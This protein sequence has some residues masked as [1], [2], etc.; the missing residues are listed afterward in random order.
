[1]G[2]EVRAVALAM[3]AAGYSVLPITIGSKKPSIHSWAPYQKLRM[4][5][6][7]IERE[8]SKDVQIAVICGAIS[9]CLEVIDFDLPKGGNLDHFKQFMALCRDFDRA[10]LIKRLAIAKT[11]SGGRHLFYRCPEGVESNK[12]LAENQNREVLIETRG[13]GGYV[14][15]APSSGYA[16]KQGGFE[17]IPTITQDDRKFLL[18]IAAMLSEKVREVYQYERVSA[19]LMTGDRPGD[20]YS[21]RASAPRLRQ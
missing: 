17:S 6:A 8:F 15:V 21:D 18:G 2:V 3:V 9:G 4:S 1:M 19:P 16:W 14:L 5:T 11:P 10:D 20:V 12:K 13:D 7:D